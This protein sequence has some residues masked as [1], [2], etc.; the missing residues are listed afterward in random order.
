MA[1]SVFIFCQKSLK[2]ILIERSDCIEISKEDKICYFVLCYYL[3]SL[4]ISL[5]ISSVFPFFPLP[6]KVSFQ[7]HPYAHPLTAAFRVAFGIP[8]TPYMSYPQKKKKPCSLPGIGLCLLRNSNL[9]FT[10]LP[11]CLTMFII[12]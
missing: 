8:Q 10:P 2:H 1:R 9:N 6:H 5:F 11:L 3:T 12:I 7:S 4:S